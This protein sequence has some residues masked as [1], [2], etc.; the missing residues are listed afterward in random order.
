MKIKEIYIVVVLLLI[1]IP[2]HAENLVK[3]SNLE[4]TWKFS[5]GDNPD[6]AKIDFDDS[7]WDYVKAPESWEQNGFKDYNGY[8]WYRKSF[9]LNMDIDD[10]YLFLLMGY[11]DDVDEVYLNGHL[12]GTMGT[13]PPL[14][15]TAYNQFRKYPIP[16]ELL[17]KHGK[18][19][20]AVRVYDDYYEGGITGGPLGLYY[21]NDNNYL[22]QNLAGYW[23]FKTNGQDN[24]EPKSIYGRQPGKI[25]VPLNWESQGYSDYDGLATYRCIFELNNDTRGKS[26]LVMVMGYIDDVDKVYLNGQKIGS[27]DDINKSDD[28]GS[29]YRTFRGYKIPKGLLNKSGENTLEVK[30][31]DN[32]GFGGIYE[33]PVGIT[34]E[35][36][37]KI[38][39]SKQKEKTEN[40]WYD[41]LKSFFE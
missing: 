24:I 25:F 7:D 26:D 35:T 27:I 8:A 16:I 30:V 38:L 13:F 6:W 31:Y 15:K 2:F 40:S 41:F 32:V 4:G 11:I 21:D 23:D 39:K 17:N 18:N 29:F 34:D 33:G 14:V 10:E 1:T 12:V 28:E 19:I 36:S 5:I 3:I 37:F 22:D 20:I 9:S